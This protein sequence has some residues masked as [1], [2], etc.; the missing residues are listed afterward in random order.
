MAT[1]TARTEGYSLDSTSSN[2]STSYSQFL[3][4]SA[5]NTAKTLKL[6]QQALEYISQKRLPAAI[7]QE[8]FPTFVQRYGAIYA[9][10]LSRLIAEFLGNITELN[11][12]DPYRQVGPN[13]PDEEVRPPVFEASNPTRWFEQYA[14]YAGKLNAQ[15]LK[16]YRR[17]LDLVAVG[18]LTAEAVQEKTA[19]Q[20]SQQLPVYTQRVGQLYVDLL[21]ELDELRS[22]YEEDY[23]GNILAL[24]NGHESEPINFVMLS[25]PLGGV[26][27]ASFT[28]TNTTPQRTPIRY[29]ATEVR[30]MDGVGAAFAPKVAIT[31]EVLE[32]GPSEEATISFSLQ[33]DADRY[34][35]EAPYIGFLYITGDG[36]LRVEM[37]LRVVATRASTGEV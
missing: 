4:S 23:L 34:D 14:E 31:P 20:M 35:T 11:R 1:S 16:A 30:R 21:K 9:D 36:D 5:S 10:R 26:A 18:E 7:F 15:A 13:S 27:F 17:Q 33:L 32:L 22:S 28:V 6:Y 24:A 2:W 3:T 29:I 12:H 19:A 8:Y 25:G 37:Q